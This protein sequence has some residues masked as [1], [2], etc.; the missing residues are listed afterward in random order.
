LLE[1]GQIFAQIYYYLSQ[2]CWSGENFNDALHYLHLAIDNGL[3][4]PKIRWETARLH[5]VMAIKTL[6]DGLNQFPEELKLTNR[7]IS[8]LEDNLLDL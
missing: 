7:L 5:Q 1:D 4:T 3:D 2:I 6:K 8:K